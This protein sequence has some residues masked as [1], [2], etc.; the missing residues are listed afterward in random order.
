M[1]QAVRWCGAGLVTAAVLS[2][3]AGVPGGLLPPL[4]SGAGR[5]V[6]SAWLVVAGVAL[7]AL[8]GHCGVVREGVT[9]SGG[10]QQSGAPV[11]RSGSA[12]RGGHRVNMQ[13]VSG[14]DPG[15]LRM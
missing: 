5:W 13:E 12:A 14:Q 11:V 1:G 6:V 3:V 7:A 10:R 9:S 8:G 15:G 4:E 2:L